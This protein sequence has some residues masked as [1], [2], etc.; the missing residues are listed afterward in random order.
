M[1]IK[2][3]PMLVVAALWATALLIYD[4]IKG[5]GVTG[6]VADAIA[7]RDR[8]RQ[9]RLATGLEVAVVEVDVADRRARRGQGRRGDT[10]ERPGCHRYDHSSAQHP[11]SSVRS[12]VHRLPV[13]IAPVRMHRGQLCLVRWCR[14]RQGQR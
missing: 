5:I 2:P 14:G 7:G 8:E 12:H 9:C 6:A 1:M 13:S 11:G 10:D 4:L 3:S